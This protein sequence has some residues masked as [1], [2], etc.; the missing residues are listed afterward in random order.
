MLLLRAWAMLALPRPPFSPT[1]GASPSPPAPPAAATRPAFGCT[2]PPPTSWATRRRALP[3][4]S[5]SRGRGGWGMTARRLTWTG[6]SSSCCRCGGEGA[7]AG[8]QPSVQRASGGASRWRHQSAFVPNTVV[9]TK[10]GTPARTRDCQVFNENSSPFYDDNM[11][12]ADAKALQALSP[13]D[14]QEANTK[15]SINGYLWCNMP[16]LTMRVGER[17]AAHM[18]GG[19]V[20]HAPGVAALFLRA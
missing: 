10:P 17:C 6:R 5:S 13:D 15:Y 20:A 3:G 2:A 18:P 12:A 19:R 14:L 8:L 1:G 9:L 4:P 16:G 7:F 11:A